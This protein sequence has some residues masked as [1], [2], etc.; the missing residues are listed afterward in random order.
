MTVGIL[1]VTHGPLGRHLLDTVTEMI[2]SLP[3][4][5]DAV[6]VHRHQDPETRIAAV[7]ASASRLDQGQGVLLLTD[8]FGSTPSNIA[9]RAAQARP[10][11]RVV[12]GL[13]LP[14]LVRVCNYPK[15]TL[16]AMTESAIEGG[17][18]GIVCGD[19]HAR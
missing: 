10:N 18:Q 2:G 1:L 6:E 9:A 14:M 13:N 12:A 8:A 4:P 3:L 16:D 19:S 17:R 15:L 11:T 7:L 5:A